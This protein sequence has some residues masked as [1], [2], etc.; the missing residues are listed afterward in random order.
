MTYK[1]I[2]KI[3]AVIVK[4]LNIGRYS[5]SSQRYITKHVETG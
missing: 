4:E 1:C 5:C 2:L 3:D